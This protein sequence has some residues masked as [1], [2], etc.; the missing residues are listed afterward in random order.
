MDPTSNPNEVIN[1]D[2]NAY[3]EST[4]R[5]QFTL[6]T[7]VSTLGNIKL[8]NALISDQ[9]GGSFILTRFLQLLPGYQQ[10]E[11][12]RLGLG[13]EYTINIIL[14]EIWPGKQFPVRFYTMNDRIMVD[15]VV[16]YCIIH[17]SEVLA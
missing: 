17:P 8:D 12:G 9:Y 13:E 5:N 14:D 10:F 6:V 15:G 1:P 2:E 11:S 4:H 3:Q 7:F 16:V